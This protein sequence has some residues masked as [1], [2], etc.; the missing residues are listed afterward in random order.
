MGIKSLA[1]ICRCGG[2]L[3]RIDEGLLKGSAREFWRELAGQEI[4]RIRGEQPPTPLAMSKRVR[5]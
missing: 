4:T 5:K 2:L 1:K 3:P